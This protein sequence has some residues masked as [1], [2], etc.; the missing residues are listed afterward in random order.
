MLVFKAGTMDEARDAVVKWLLWSADHETNHHLTRLKR[1]KDQAV[2]RGNTLRLYASMLK[3]SHFAPDF[4]AKPTNEPPKPKPQETFVE[5]L[6]ETRRLY[7]EERDRRQ[8]GT[9]RSVAEAKVKVV[10]LVLAKLA[11]DAKAP[12]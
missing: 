12:D 8:S 6:T 5:W 4:S 10:E 7:T 11:A 2:A 9:L 3:T 1:D